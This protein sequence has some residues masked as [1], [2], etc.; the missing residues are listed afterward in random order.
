MLQ[1]AWH[2]EVP[3]ETGS[4]TQESGV[5]QK[6]WCGLHGLNCSQ[7]SNPD[8]NAMLR[9]TAKDGEKERLEG[10][11]WYP[12]SR[13]CSSDQLPCLGPRHCRPNLPRGCG[14]VSE[15]FIQLDGNRQLA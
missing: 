8:Q 9:P 12:V 2:F 15:R 4:G 1:F 14:G 6:A 10:R 3:R 13:S 11:M 7:W 5:K